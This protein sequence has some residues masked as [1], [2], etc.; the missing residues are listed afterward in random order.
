MTARLIDGKK[1]ASDIKKNL[2]KEI[3]DLKI[4]GISPCLAVIFDGADHPS[5]KYAAL[6][7]KVCK[8]IGMNIFLYNIRELTTQRELIGLIDKLNATPKINGI[9]LQ[10]P[11]VGFDEK[12]AINKIASEKDIDG[13]SPSALNKLRHDKPYFIPSTSYGIIKMLEAYGINIE[14]KHAVIV[15]N[16]RIGNNGEF[17]SFLLSKK[18]ATV[19][20]CFSKAPNLK[21]ECLK[22]DILCVA[23]GVPKMITAD[24]VKTGT[25]V[26]DMGMN[27][28]SNGKIVGDVDFDDLKEKTAYITPV[29]GCIGP[30]TIAM[31]MHN[32]VL[33][34]KMQAKILQR[35]D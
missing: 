27:V 22:A 12:D 18:N 26:I 33:A 1:I 4:K 7:K 9:L 31:L 15:E 17:L 2:K 29:P 10:F 21:E 6:K 3:S 19:T 5:E 11:L 32:T 25:I 13:C 24:M 16:C 20:T 8:E 14:G 30:M 34:A 23:A 35:H 28:T